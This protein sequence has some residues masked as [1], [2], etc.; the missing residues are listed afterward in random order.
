MADIHQ[1]RILILDFG[2]QYTQ[3]IAR[4]VREAGVYCELHPYDMDAAAIRDFHPRG[5]IL[6]GGPESVTLTETPRAQQVVFELGVPVLGICYGMQ[7]MA[8]QLGGGV[9]SSTRREF[10]YARVRARGHS[11]LLRDIEDHTSPE[12]YGLLD[13]WM[14]HGDRVEQLPPG[15]K[16][17]ASSDSAPLAGMA[18]EERGFYGLQFHPEVT[19]TRQGVRILNRFVHDIC[20]CASDWTSSNI[21]DDSI[22]QIRTQVGEDQVLLALSGGVDSS[23]V[24]ALLHRAIGDQLTCVFVDNGLLRLDEGDQVMATFAKHMGIRVI[25]VDAEERF[26]QA[27]RGIADPEQKRRI[28]GNL[29]VEVFEEQAAQLTK[30][31]WLAQGTIYPD[32][33]ESAGAKT[34]KAHVIKTHHNVGGL[35]AAMRLKLIEPLRELFKDEV[36]KIGVELGLPSEMVYRHPFPGPGLGVRILG[37]VKK[38]YADLLRRADAIFIEELHRQEWYD[39]VSQAFTVFLPV[40]SVGVMGDGRRYDYVVSLRAVQTV[41][42]MTAHWAP[43]P[44]DLLGTVSNRIINEVSGISRVVYDISGKPPA[45]IE[46]E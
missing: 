10:G 28:I 18:D 17:I 38:E 44:Y 22:A 19:H 9:A 24:A 30:V 7:T 31:K 23:V 35:P 41:D 36:R 26:L 16:L 33:I 14:S 32:V 45:T 46:W 5:I 2:S 21:I 37:E 42:F 12:G 25:R 27:L 34:G 43:L 15:F 6:S 40:R 3:L 20:G 13:V 11:R 29:F 39:K 4:R 1:H 8:V